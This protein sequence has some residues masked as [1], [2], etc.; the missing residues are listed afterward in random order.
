MDRAAHGRLD[1]AG[2]SPPL[3]RLRRIAELLPARQ[4]AGGSP[5]S[6]ARGS[7]AR[8]SVA[9]GSGARGSGTSAG[10]ALARQEGIVEVNVLALEAGPGEHPDGLAHHLLRARDVRLAVGV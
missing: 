7:V 10:P 3:R 1:H 6:V 4:L 8:G 9:R 5:G 2:V